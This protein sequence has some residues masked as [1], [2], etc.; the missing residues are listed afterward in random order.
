MG[1]IKTPAQ[2]E[3][4]RASGRLCALAMQAMQ[5]AIV[6]GVTTATLDAIAREVIAKGGGTPCFLGYNGYPAAICASANQVVVHGI[7]NH[8]PL[9]Q[10]DILSIDVGVSLD[11]WLSDMAR[12]YPVGT[13]SA[14]AMALIAITQQCF[15]A[16]MRQ[17]IPGRRIGDISA[18][19]QRVAEGAGYG[20]VR[21]LTGHGIGQAMHEEPSVPNY[22]TPGRGLLLR[23]GMT[24]AIEPMITQGDW[25]V[26]T[27]ADGWTVVTAD[28]KWSSHHE[29]TV[30]VTAQ[31]PEILTPMAGAT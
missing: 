15:E 30:L 14:E 9:L 4:M 1:L 5:A 3:L 11:G 13:A 25:R 20:V 22:G 19:V 29:N 2:I 10:G 17:A 21:A 31:G 27:R 16:G 24:I 6:P 26:N 8:Q 7:P 28:G 18:A 12:T 23:E